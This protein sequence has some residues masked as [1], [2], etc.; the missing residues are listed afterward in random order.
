MW[1]FTIII[2]CGQEK[3]QEGNSQFEAQS[4]FDANLYHDKTSQT[5]ITEFVQNHNDD[6]II[7]DK[8]A[9][10]LY[11]FKNK[12]LQSGYPVPIALGFEPVKAKEK[13]GDGR[14]P[15]GEFYLYSRVSGHSQFAYF[16]GISYPNEK[17]AERGLKDGI[18]NNNQYKTILEQLKNKQRPLMNTNLGGEIGIHTMLQGDSHPVGTVTASNWT[19]GCIALEFQDMIRLFNQSR[20]GI[21]VFIIGETHKQNY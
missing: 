10:K 19:L 4:D 16:M 18:I 9:M 7:I 13:S 14:T 5:I 21:R 3:V 12:Q 15:E 1:F 6:L 11:F 2:S 17:N 8:T 20:I